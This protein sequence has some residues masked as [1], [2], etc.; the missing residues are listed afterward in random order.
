MGANFFR[1]P[2]RSQSQVLL[3]TTEE[4]PVTCGA[5]LGDT[6]ARIDPIDDGAKDLRS[7]AA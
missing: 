6:R 2:D 1:F 3:E 5:G 7:W 4:S